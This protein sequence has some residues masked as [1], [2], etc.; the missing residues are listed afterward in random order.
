MNRRDFLK[1]LGLTPVVVA[2]PRFIFDMGANL[3]KPQPPARG[4]DI[5]LWAPNQIYDLVSGMTKP[6]DA[7]IKALI[8]DFNRNH[9]EYIYARDRRVEQMRKFY[10]DTK[11]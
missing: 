6:I 7:E 10:E 4:Y 1:M 5:V 2:A 11:W 9:S 3:Y 8:A